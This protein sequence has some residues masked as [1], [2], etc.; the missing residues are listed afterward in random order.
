MICKDF[1]K[2]FFTRQV[3]RPQARH[4]NRQGLQAFLGYPDTNILQ[5]QGSWAWNTWNIYMYLGFLIWCLLN[6]YFSSCHSMKNDLFCPVT[7][8]QAQGTRPH[9]S[10]NCTNVQESNSTFLT[11]CWGSHLGRWELTGLKNAWK[12]HLHLTAQRLITLRL[13]SVAPDR[14]WSQQL[15]RSMA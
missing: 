12:I 4:E 8:N 2:F 14:K 3:E 9:E 6:E 7:C 13:A 10:I 15:M 11:V 5:A 1:R